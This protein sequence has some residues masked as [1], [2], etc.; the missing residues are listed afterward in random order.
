M[1]QDQHQHVKER[2]R[3]QY[4]HLTASQKIISKIAL[5]KPSLLAIH[6]AKKI[7]ELTNTSEAT[8][9][10]F[11]YA[12]GYSGYTELQEEIKKSLLIGDQRKGP[13]QKYRDTEAALTRDNYAHQ[14]IETDIAYL[15]QSLQ[16]IDYGLLHQAVQSIMAAHRIVVVGFRWCHIPAKWLFSALNAIK[17]NTHLYTGA[18]DN[19]DYFLTEREQEW[20]VIALSFPRH[21]SETVA[22]V[23]SAKALGAK[24]LAITEGEL[25]PISQAADLLLKITTPQPVATSGMPTLFSVLNVLVKGVMVH[26]AARVQ[27]R[28]QHY[29]EISSKLYSFVGEEE[30]DFSIY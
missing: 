29:D 8:V 17:G 4:G 25:S 11:C 28:L 1:D 2:I 12:L 26:D 16:Q 21:P 18:V 6:T 30:E 22:M 14:V 23:H 24:V 13:I 10:R 27:Q 5:E 9:I 19:A 15:Q 3:K 20:L 7:A